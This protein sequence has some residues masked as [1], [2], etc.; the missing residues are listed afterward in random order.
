[1]DIKGLPDA[2]NSAF[3]ETQIRLCIVHRIRYSLK[4]VTWKHYKAV[5]SDLKQVYKSATEEDALLAL[6]RFAEKWDE[7]YP[8]ISKS[9]RNHWQNLNTLFNYSEE[10]RKTIYTTNA[11]ESLNSVIRKATN[12]RKLFSTDNSAKK[13]IYLAVQAASKNG[14]CPFEIGNWL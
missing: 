4:Y 14:R 12:R 6:D 10:I 8:L 9:L 2:I 7:R 1:M 3:P 13:V 5:T 11:I